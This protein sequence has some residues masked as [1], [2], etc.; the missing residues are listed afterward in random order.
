MDRARPVT[1]LALN[2]LQALGVAQRRA[3]NLAVAGDMA[4]HAIVVR[5]LSDLDEGFPCLGM[6]GVLPEARGRLV[7]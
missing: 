6:K 4:A 3:A 7:A 2:I 1:D 5:F